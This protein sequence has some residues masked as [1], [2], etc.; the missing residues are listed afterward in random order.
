LAEEA[1]ERIA[2]DCRL[3]LRFDKQLA[4]SDGKLKLTEAGDVL[5]VRINISAYP[6]KRDSSQKNEGIHRFWL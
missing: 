3:Y 1:V 5:H 4:V 6:A 2:E